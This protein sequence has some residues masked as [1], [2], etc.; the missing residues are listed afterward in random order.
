M[1]DHVE[2]TFSSIEGY[3][4][5]LS[6]INSNYLD[7]AY[8]QLSQS[9]DLGSSILQAGWRFSGKSEIFKAVREGKKQIKKIEEAN[10][11]LISIL[12]RVQSTYESA[13]ATEAGKNNVSWLNTALGALGVITLGIR[14][15]ILAP[16][17]SIWAGKKIVSSVSRAGKGVF[18]KISSSASKLLTAGITALSSVSVVS[19]LKGKQS[20]LGADAAGK[21]D[22]ALVGAAAAAATPPAAA[23]TPAA[24]PVAAAAV[25]KEEPFDK[26]EDSITKYENAPYAWGGTSPSGIDCSGLVMQVYK[27]AGIK[28]DFVHQSA[29]MYKQCQP[30]TD[31]PVNNV[32]LSAMKKGD[33]VFYSNAGTEAIKHVGIYVGDGQVVSALS[34][35]VSKESISH[36]NYKNIYVARVAE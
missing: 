13:A 8:R 3:I 30:V 1:A 6:V 14:P 19:H 31:F 20:L 5:K 35:G 33:P 18:P 15:S 25:A 4:A 26:I 28:T 16:V 36:T 27:E 21:T 34:K 7:V 24:S 29:E 23:A 10:N 22:G 12:N 9:T 17:F 11:K 32:D 2:L